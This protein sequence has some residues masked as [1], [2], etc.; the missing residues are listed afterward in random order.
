[1]TLLREGETKKAVTYFL[2]GINKESQFLILEKQMEPTLAAISYLQSA[3]VFFL[4]AI[5]NGSKAPQVYDQLTSIIA[6]KE[7]LT[8][9]LLG[10]SNKK[11]HITKLIKP[12]KIAHLLPADLYLNYGL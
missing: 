3:T 7:R 12:S 2:K 9:S 4:K 8:K 1:M 5:E 10:F 6:V 11:N